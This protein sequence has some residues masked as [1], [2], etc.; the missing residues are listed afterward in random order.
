MLAACARKKVRHEDR[1]RW[2]AGRSPA[3]SNTL[4]TEV[5]E[6]ETPSPLSS[7]T[8]RR[9]PQCGFSLASRRIS[10]RSDHSIGGRPGIRL[11]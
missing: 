7:P 5:A 11:A 6:T 10:S 2:G 9:Y 1:V 8:I 3:S 4:R